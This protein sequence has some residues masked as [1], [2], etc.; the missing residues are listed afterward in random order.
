MVAYDESFARS[1]Y[2]KLPVGA[3]VGA[4]FRVIGR[5]WVPLYAISLV[6]TLASLPSAYLLGK[7]MGAVVA[8]S[9]AGSGVGSSATVPHVAQGTY[10][11]LGS[12]YLV[13]TLLSLYAFGVV[14]E[15]TSRMLQNGSFGLTPAL[16]TGLVRFLPMLVSAVSFYVLFVIGFALLLVPGIL[17]G[18]VYGLAPALCVIERRGPFNSFSR[19]A[20]LTRDNRWRCIGV[21][22]L[23]MVGPIIVGSA[24]GGGLGV[25]LGPKNNAYASALANFFLLPIFY[26]FPAALACNLKRLKEG[27]GPATVAEVF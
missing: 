3:T 15:G 7:V 12:F 1:A 23:L 24:I 20:A 9:K 13:Q 4:T 22:L 11:I 26:V 5:S 8:M 25:A 16:K 6:L 17:V 2:P 27:G 19:S 21:T 18:A 10:A 14:S